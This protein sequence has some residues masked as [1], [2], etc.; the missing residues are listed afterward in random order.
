MSKPLALSDSAF[1][2]IVAASQ[3]LAVS[4]RSCFLRDVAA[5]LGSQSELGDGLISR[6]CSE[7]PRGHQWTAARAQIRALIVLASRVW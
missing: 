7:R 1:T 6:I 5:V 4:D 3:P 2:I